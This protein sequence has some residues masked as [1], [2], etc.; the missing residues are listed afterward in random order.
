M[1]GPSLPRPRQ[2]VILA[3]GRGERMRPLSDL[4]PKPMIEVAGKPL[5][6][7]LLI[8]LTRAGLTRVLILTGYMG[9]VISDY[10]G[11]GATWGMDLSYH[12]SP[13]DYDTGARLAAA[14]DLL[15]PLLLLLYADNLWPL[16]FEAMCAAFARAATPAML[17]AYR[18]DDN[19]SRSN[20]RLQD[21]LVSAYDKARAAPNLTHVDIGFLFLQRQVLDLLPPSPGNFEAVLYPKLAAAKQLAAF[22]TSHRYY[23]AT[24]PDRLPRVEAYL[25]PKPTVLLDRDGVLNEKAPK[26]EYVSSWKDFRWCKG[27]LEALK[28]LRAN[29]YRVIVI[30]NQAGIARGMLTH[31]AVQDIHR[32]MAREAEAGGGFIEAVYYCPHHWDEACA[33]RKPKPGMLLAAQRDFSLNLS[34]CVYIGDDPRD[35]VAAEAAHCPFIPIDGKRDLLAAVKCLIADRKCAENEQDAR[36]RQRPKKGKKVS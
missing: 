11:D 19:Y 10:F 9:D 21:G 25:R 2:A 17:T 31:E 16:P 6:E 22:E 14:R 12:H 8:E 24:S 32:H 28:L 20:C 7:H 35:G 36:S 18:N 15:D 4:R 33:C 1:S 27:A 5:L 3:G 26:A 13:E 29:G 34:R 30:S 23:S